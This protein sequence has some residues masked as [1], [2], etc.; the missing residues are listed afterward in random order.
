[1]K[2]LARA[3]RLLAATLREPFPATR[4]ADYVSEWIDYLAETWPLWSF[5][6]ARYVE[7]EGSGWFSTEALRQ[8]VHT[9]RSDDGVAKLKKLSP[10]ETELD[11]RRYRFARAVLP[12][13]AIPALP[14]ASDEL[15]SGSCLFCRLHFLGLEPE[16]GYAEEYEKV[17]LQF[18]LHVV[19]L[20][21]SAKGARAR[22]ERGILRFAR[23]LA[24]QGRRGRRQEGPSK[25]LLKALVA[26]G[27]ELIEVCWHALGSPWPAASQPFRRLGLRDAEIRDWSARLALPVLS[28]CQITALCAEI[29]RAATWP[30]TKGGRPTARRFTIWVLSRRL[31]LDAR[32]LARKALGTAASER[33]RGQNP[34]DVAR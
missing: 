33:F 17:G 34:I 12:N 14:L 5:Q 26:E 1:M 7:L 30:S 15:R 21:N 4:R 13:V 31:K 23:S 19:K 25:P 6:R 28:S 29:S 2:D 10:L 32:S 11:H 20:R 18:M 22:A 16:G 27:R 9:L 8:I 24:K 3:Q